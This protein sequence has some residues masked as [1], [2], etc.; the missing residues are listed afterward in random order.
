MGDAFVLKIARKE[1]NEKEEKIYRKS[2]QFRRTTN[3]SVA[4][5]AHLIFLKYVKRLTV[6]GVTIF[7]YWMSYPD[8]LK[9]MH[10]HFFFLL[11]SEVSR[12]RLHG[13]AVLETF[14]DCCK[15]RTKKNIIIIK[16]SVL[17]RI[18]AVYLLCSWC[19]FL[20]ANVDAS[21]ACT[22]QIV[23]DLYALGN[24]VP[25]EKNPLAGD[26]VAITTHTLFVCAQT[27][28]QVQ[29][30]RQTHISTHEKR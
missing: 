26:M 16:N 7:I 27:I 1:R 5:F 19:W 18:L 11:R 17:W 13:C 24:Y 22:L 9:L 4:F 20:C 12:C 29:V 25:S 30:A 3:K 10:C 8:K 6:D 15:W 23:V 2:V 14:S 28:R 21:I